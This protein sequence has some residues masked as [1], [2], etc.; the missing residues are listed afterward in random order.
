MSRLAQVQNLAIKYPI[1]Y[2]F[3]YPLTY[4]SAYG[5]RPVQ[6]VRSCLDK[7]GA[8]VIFMPNLTNPS[9][10]IETRAQRFYQRFSNVMD[11]HEK[12]HLVAHSFAGVDMRAMINFFDLQDKVASLSTLCSPHNGLTLLERIPNNPDSKEHLLN[13]LRPVGMNSHN[14]K[15]FFP[16]TM[17]NINEEIA[18]SET[19]AKFSFGSRTT[20]QNVEKM[21]RYTAS[22]ITDES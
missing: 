15:E 14:V 17:A 2:A 18:D 16:N 8:D 5:Y 12:F 21:L 22:A 19:F 10:T 9:S 4:Y 1:V 20:Q 6:K 13:A 11:E 3:N 7:Q